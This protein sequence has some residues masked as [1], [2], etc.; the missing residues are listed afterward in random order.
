MQPV[1]D[2]IVACLGAVRSSSLFHGSSLCHVDNHV[3]AARPQV[4]FDWKH[5]ATGNALHLKKRAIG[6]VAQEV[7]TAFPELVH[8]CVISRGATGRPLT[9]AVHV[10]AALTSWKF[11]FAI[12]MDVHKARN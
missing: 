4:T 3:N 11:V 2:S 7:Q 5:E 12:L 8:R 9:L 1:V 10:S 6:F